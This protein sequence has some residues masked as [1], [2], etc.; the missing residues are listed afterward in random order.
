MVH[1]RNKGVRGELELAEFLRDSGF[2][3]RRGQQHAGGGD[4]PDVVTNI[5]NVHFECKRVEAGNPYIWLD[6]A[7]RDTGRT[8][9]ILN[10]MPIV[11]HRRNGKDWIAI[12]RLEDLLQ[13]LK[14]AK[15]A[16]CLTAL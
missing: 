9:G 11:A 4:S 2:E 12:M 16:E 7:T 1:S 8:L 10:K 3:A 15:S 14:D 13:L 6:Q 5:D